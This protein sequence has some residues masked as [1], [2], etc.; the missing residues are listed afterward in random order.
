MQEKKDLEI[1]KKFDI[2]IKALEQE[3]MKLAKALN[4]KDS[5]D[6]ENI[7]TVAGVDIISLGNK[8]IVGIVVMEEGEIV[9]QKFCT[10]KASFP[11][12]SGFRA[13]RELPAIISCFESL[14]NKPQ[15]IF[16]KG[17]GTSHPRKMGIASH[18]SLSVNLPVIGVA[19]ELIAGVGQVE[20]DNIILDGEVVGKLVHVKEG[21]RPLYVSP[22]NLI[23]IETSAEFVKKSVKEPHKLPEPLRLARNLVK[24]VLRELH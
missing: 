13:Y 6:T 2:D 10:E 18:L 5:F 23:S 11:Y 17:H 19:D 3:Q 1:A 14:E 22:G 20:K 15:L 21:A 7:I 8:L 24:K 4:L 9:E 12:V 16:I